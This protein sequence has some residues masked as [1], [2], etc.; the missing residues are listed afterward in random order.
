M[1]FLGVYTLLFTL[2]SY[3][4]IGLHPGGRAFFRFLA[5]WY[6]ATPA[7]ESQ[8]LVVAALMPMFVAALAI[9]AFVNRFWMSVGGY[10]IKARSLPGFWFYSFH[11]MD[12]QHYAFELLTNTCAVS[13]TDVLDNLHIGG[14]SYG[15]WAGIVTGITVIYWIVHHRPG[16]PSR[17]R[18]CTAP[19]RTRPHITLTPPADSLA[20]YTVVPSGSPRAHSILN[21]AVLGPD[22]RTHFHISSDDAA[23]V[24]EEASGRRRV[25][26]I[27]WA[28]AHP[29]L[30]LD[31]L[32]WPLR[33]SQWLYLSS[34]R[35]CRTMI[36]GG[37]QFSWRPNGGFVE[38]FPLANS[39]ASQPLARISL[40]LS[41][42]QG[43][44]NLITL[45]LT[46]QALQKRLLKAT[47]VSAVLLMSGR[48]ID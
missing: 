4:A 22:N 16:A 40:S 24:V 11:Y 9:G 15:A 8:M 17:N 2:I 29:T 13:G 26:V 38:L 18:L 35:A 27:T 25:A 5:F 23:T 33:T 45:Q 19:S 7:A 28:G 36:A 48:R 37:E 44:G 21:S 14:I 30:A 43:A 32:G 20:T 42:S 3:W 6:L 46:P 12:Y 47:V 1:P 10:F 39:E 34:D 41:R 31:G